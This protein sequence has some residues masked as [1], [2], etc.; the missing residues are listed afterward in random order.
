MVQVE[1]RYFVILDHKT[2]DLEGM[3]LLYNFL[4][5]LLFSHLHVA[6]VK[7]LSILTSSFPT[8]CLCACECVRTHAQSLSYLQLFA[9]PWTVTHKAPLSTES[10]RQEDWIRLP[11]PPPGESSQPRDRSHVSCSSCI[12]RQVL[13]HCATWE[14]LFACV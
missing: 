1:R 3:N 6:S 14:S 10:S 11:F 13:Y 5:M 9:T 8:L 7:E 12:G 4:A 2:Q